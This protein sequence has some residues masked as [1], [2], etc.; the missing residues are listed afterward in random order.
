MDHSKLTMVILAGG[1]S[2]RMGKNKANLILGNK[3]IID[4]MI[5]KGQE[6]GFGEILLSGYEEERQGTRTVPDILRG[7]GPLGGIHGSL[8]ASENPWAFVLPVDCPGIGTATIAN[9]VETHFSNG[10]EVTLLRNGGRIQPLIGIYPKE[11]A[12]TIES[13]ILWGSAPVFRALDRVKWQAYPLEAG[14]PLI[15]NLNTKEAFHAY[16]L[17]YQQDLE[18]KP[19]G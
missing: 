3:K 18:G 15:L 11:F 16:R 5:H 4:L 6:L 7:R 1:K 17:K 8:C 13:L 14:Q 9:M 2:S 12:S 19:G 10:H